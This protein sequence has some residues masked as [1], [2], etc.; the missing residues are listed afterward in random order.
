MRNYAWH[1]Y[2]APICCGDVLWL[3]RPRWKAPGRIVLTGSQRSPD[4]GSSDAPENLIASV[5]WAANG[6][7]PSGL[8]TL[9]WPFCMQA[10]QMANV[11]YFRVRL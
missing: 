7:R 8:G 4:R 9:Q 10:H 5:Y 1:R 6:P 2:F 3:V 11:P